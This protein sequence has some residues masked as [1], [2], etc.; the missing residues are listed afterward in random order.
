MKTDL[1]RWLSLTSILKA[2]K[3]IGVFLNKRSSNLMPFDGRSGN[4]RNLLFSVTDGDPD[5]IPSVDPYSDLDP[6]LSNGQGIFYKG[7]LSLKSSCWLFCPCP[8]YVF[9]KFFSF[10]YNDRQSVDYP[11]W[12]V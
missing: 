1:T 4:S 12:Y 3:N 8:A 9:S 11:T 6:E 7:F 5:G 2:L 10:Y